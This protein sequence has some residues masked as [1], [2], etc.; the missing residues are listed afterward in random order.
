MNIEEIIKKIDKI[1]ANQIA[2]AFALQV[3]ARNMPGDISKM[4]DDYDARCAQYM[5]LLLEN[6]PPHLLD[7]EREA[8][9]S[10]GRHVFRAQH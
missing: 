10:L 1:H 6:T 7:A 9:R 4:G 3:L 5:A 2:F 8:I